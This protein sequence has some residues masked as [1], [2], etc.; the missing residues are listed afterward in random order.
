ML[1]KR[2]QR[3]RLAS[4]LSLR[5]LAKKIDV[6]HNAIKKYEH[7]EMV[8]SS[9]VLIKMA[10]ELGVRVEYFFRADIVDLK[11][12]QYRS[13]H[14]TANKKDLLAIKADILDQIERRL[15]LENL[16]PSTGVEKYKPV[17]SESTLNSFDEIES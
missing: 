13:K 10:K 15:E 1:S 5:V 4:G 12:I 14:K 11:T 3:A 2:I 17:K 16:L 9:G 6:S 8:P 7:G